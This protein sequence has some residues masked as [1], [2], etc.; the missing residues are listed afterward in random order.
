MKVNND[1][2]IIEVDE[3]R[4]PLRDAVREASGL[5]GRQEGAVLLVSVVTLSLL[6]LAGLGT[7]EQTLVSDRA[8]SAGRAGQ[9][10]LQEASEGVSQ[11]IEDLLSGDMPTFSGCGNT[12]DANW[13]CTVEGDGFTY[14]VSYIKSG[15]DIAADSAGNK[16]YHIKSVG[17]SGSEANTSAEKT[18]SAGIALGGAEAD[19]VWSDTLVACSYLDIKAHSNQDGVTINGD[20]RTLE[21]GATVKIKDYVVIDGDL[22]HTDSDPDIYDSQVDIRGSTTLVAPT[23]CDPL[24]INQMFS[25]LRNTKLNGNEPNE[26]L[27]K[28]DDMAFGAGDADGDG[29]ALNDFYK[30][31]HFKLKD[32]DITVEGN[33][34]IYVGEKFELK[35]ATIELIDDATL[36]L[37]LGGP[38]KNK[39]IKIEN[40]GLVGVGTDSSPETRVFMYAEDSGD[41]DDDNSI[42]ISQNG[43]KRVCYE[44]KNG[45]LTDEEL[46]C[47]DNDASEPI[48]RPATPWGGL[49]Y[50]P[51]ADVYLQNAYLSGAVWADKINIS[52]D[53][54]DDNK[55]QKNKATQINYAE[56]LSEGDGEENRE[57]DYKVLYYTEGDV[58]FAAG[59]AMDG[60]AEEQA[61]STF[62]VS[63]A[64]HNHQGTNLRVTLNN[65]DTENGVT[66]ISAS[67]TSMPSGVSVKEVKDDSADIA[68]SGSHQVT[69][70]LN[71]PGQGGTSNLDGDYG[72]TF[73]FSDGSEVNGNVSVVQGGLGQENDEVQ[74]EEH[75]EH[76]PEQPTQ[77]S[78]RVSNVDRDDEEVEFSF[79]DTN[80]VGL[81]VASVRF[82]N[83]PEGAEL[84]KIEF[85]D[86]SNN[87]EVKHEN[88]PR[89]L[90]NFNANK[91][92]FKDD[93][94]LQL[95][96]KNGDEVRG[97]YTFTI[98][99]SDGTQITFDGNVG[100]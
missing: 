96:F 35:N 32:H 68:A 10:A 41:D 90:D 45:S 83:F 25:V 91:R 59:A 56:S 21:E 65:N 66:L 24:D 18:I 27:D 40:S 20:V 46:D 97:R 33:V 15:D 98:T 37:Y 50:A 63:I 54:D 28:N 60:D 87:V 57:K 44:I 94:S 8:A 70:Q 6:A 79:G 39:K 43:P 88:L 71:A 11:A 85:G 9:Q 13:S 69:F 12:D 30:Y 95:E 93:S 36:T 52:D 100:G 23:E 67:L 5:H 26:K 2:H 75:N 78:M 1:K 31:K 80:L 19:G 14:T 76:V 3:S 58:K 61:P 72:V 64:S 55:Q 86:N 38:D 22:N 53:D 17:K 4:I 89:V 82:D 48:D 74:N 84:K 47:D 99:L 7:V 73:V 29:S 49:I 42:K 62:D 77:I 16:L 81:S 34:T 92:W 51:Q